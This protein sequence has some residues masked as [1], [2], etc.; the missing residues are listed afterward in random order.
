MQALQG[1]QNGAGWRSCNTADMYLKVKSLNHF[2]AFFSYFQKNGGMVSW[3]RPWPP[4]SISSSNHHSQPSSHLIRHK[5]M[6][7][8]GTK[9]LHNLRIN[10]NNGF[11]LFNY[12]QDYISI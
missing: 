2:M 11:Q 10:Q 9:P 4:H 12:F 1:S 3:N 8:V 7:A 6:S 5:K